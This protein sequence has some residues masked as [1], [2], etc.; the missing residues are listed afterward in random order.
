MVFS[1]PLKI[2]QLQYMVGV[3]FIGGGDQSTRRKPPTCHRS[4]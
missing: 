4:L 3:S 1:A 2:F